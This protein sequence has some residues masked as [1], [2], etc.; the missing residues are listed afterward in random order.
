MPRP[1]GGV[2]AGVPGEAGIPGAWG[3]CAPR[4]RGEVRNGT[5]EICCSFVQ[6]LMSSSHAQRLLLS[7]VLRGDFDRVERVI[8]VAVAFQGLDDGKG[9]RKFFAFWVVE[10]RLKTEEQIALD[11]RLKEMDMPYIIEKWKQE[12][13]EAGWTKGLVEGRAE[14]LAQG[15]EEGLEKGL[16]E[17]LRRKSLETA[18]RMLAEGFAW[19]VVTRITGVAP[20]DLAE[21]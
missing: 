4:R 2:W 12:G 13:L 5:A 9:Y 3:A 1:Y 18:Q 16:E 15:M 7:R 20:E 14:G 21:A 8:E 11:R 17:G 10:G 6:Y 19:E